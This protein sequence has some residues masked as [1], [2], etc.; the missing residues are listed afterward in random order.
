VKDVR[1]AFEKTDSA[2]VL[3]GD[4]DDFMLSLLQR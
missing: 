4:I 3:D 1:T 2:A